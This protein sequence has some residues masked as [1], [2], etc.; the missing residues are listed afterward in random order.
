M[1]MQY[2]HMCLVLMFWFN[3]NSM[4]QTDAR[5]RTHTLAHTFAHAKE[6]NKSR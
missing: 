2:T 5:D 3:L 4:E 1:P 6:R